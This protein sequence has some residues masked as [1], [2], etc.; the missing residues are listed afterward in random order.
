M[1]NSPT[2]C[3]SM[4]V[5]NEAHCI[6]KCLNSV[7]NFIDYWI[8]C[9]TGS[10]DNTKEIVEKCLNGIPGE[11]H[12][13]DWEDFSTNRNKSLSLAKDKADYT[14]VIDADDY[15]VIQDTNIFKKIDAPAYNIRFQHSS[16]SYHRVQLFKNSLKSRYVGVLHEY[17]ELPTVQ[18]KNLYGCYIQYGG[19]GARSK[20]ATKFLKDAEVFEKALLTEPS[21]SRNVFYCAQSYRDAG[22]LDQALIK[23]KQRSTMGGWDE[24][25]FVSLLEAGKLIEILF[26]DKVEEVESVYLSAYNCVPS[27]VES[28]CYLASYCRRKKLF[29]H[30][31]FYAKIGSKIDKP[32]DGLFLE[33]ACYDWKIQDE[34]AISAYYIG[35]ISEFEFVTKNLI[36]NVKIPGPDKAR[37]M[38]NFQFVR[39]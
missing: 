19:V 7:K 3:L 18:I 22:K 11:F 21:N 4:I 30:A 36:N 9:D 13:H 14:L 26:F 28:L 38:N 34:L 16:I 39:K 31:Y 25:R 37:I 10:T 8:I 12:Q 20:D 24:E 6:E 27:R 33:P 1:K 29:N 23:Y 2:I 5:K 35:K 17:L 32:S 15:L